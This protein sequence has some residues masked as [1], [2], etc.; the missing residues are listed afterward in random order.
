VLK[1]GNR[2]GFEESLRTEDAM[3]NVQTRLIAGE[4]NLDKAKHSLE[5]HRFCGSNGGF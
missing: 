5:K 4:A 1:G 3:Q 2:L